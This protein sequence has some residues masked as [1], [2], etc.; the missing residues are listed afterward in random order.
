MGLDLLGP[1][2]TRIATYLDSLTWVEIAL[3]L[4]SLC[5]AISYAR[6]KGYPTVPGAPVYGYNSRFEPSFMLK[7]RTYTGFY[8]ILSK[9]YTM[10]KDVPFVIPRHD[11]NINIL[12]IKYLDEIR[13]MPKHILNSHLVLISQMTPKWTWLQPAADSDLV[14]RVLL[15]KLNPD[16]Q[17]YVDITRLELDSAFKSD[18]PRHD[19]EWT[20]VDF[21]PLIRRVLTRISAKIFLGEPACLN[22]DWLRIAIGYTAGALEVTKDLHKFPSWTHFLVAPLLPSRRRLRRELDIAMK[23]VEKQIQLHDQAERDGVKNDD[24]L[25]D[26]MLDNCSDKENGVEAMTIFQCFIAMA[27]IHTTEFS[28]ANVL[29]DLCAHPEWFPVLREELDEVIRAH[30]HIGE[31]LPAKQWLQKLEKMDSLLAETL[32]LYPTMLTSIQRLALEKVQLKDGTVIPKGAR[33][34]WASLH[35]VTDPDVDGTLAAWDPMRNYRKRHSSSGENLNK[36]VAGQINE[37]TLGFG[38][39]NQACPGRY[40]AV[41]EIK[42]MLA[43]LLLEFEFKFPE[44]KSRPKVFFVGEIACLDHDATLMM[45]KVRTC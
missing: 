13:L 3:P 11:T 5:W 29:F 31:K 38:Y 23:I 33:L 21:Q 22:E 2:A 30:G 18:F 25:L 27:S 1:A 45:R 12:P 10:L 44:G 8:D 28:L 9:G 7:S 34:A 35:H 26:W 32:R 42:M 37:S 36:F 24:T 16:L 14:T 4:F 41:N 43:R 40:F 15:T 39:G 19:E 6:G 20:E 17:K